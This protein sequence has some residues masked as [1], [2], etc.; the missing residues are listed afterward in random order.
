MNR[1]L[2]INGSYIKNSIHQARER[3]K[4]Q[5]RDIR[6]WCYPRPKLAP[7]SI[8]TT[9]NSDRRIPPRC[10]IKSTM[11]TI[12]DYFS[13]KPTTSN[14][15]PNHNTRLSPPKPRVRVSKA[16]K[17]IQAMLKITQRTQPSSTS[18]S[19]NP[20]NVT[21]QTTTTTATS[22]MHKHRGIE[23]VNESVQKGSTIA[24]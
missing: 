13:G 12:Q 17:Y 10:S 15:P 6:Q 5:V 24:T 16:Q 14:Q 20:P 23:P 19:V 18:K 21:D 11:K 9:E 2:E 22:P 8:K 4:Q 1:W 7:P 3:Q